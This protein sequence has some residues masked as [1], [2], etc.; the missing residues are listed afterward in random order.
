MQQRWGMWVA[1][2]PLIPFLL[3][4]VDALG[5]SS[6]GGLAT[7]LISII[8]CVRRWRVDLTIMDSLLANAEMATYSQR[9]LCLRLLL[10]R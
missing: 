5:T 2:V 7:L 9:V 3:E 6:C 10:L 1:S 8:L 4:N